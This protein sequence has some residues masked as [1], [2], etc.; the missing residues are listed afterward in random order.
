MQHCNLEHGISAVQS[1]HHAGG[2]ILAGTDAPN[3]GTAQRQPKRSLS[4]FE[5]AWLAAGSP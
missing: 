2:T 4:R 5:K 3:P 1:I